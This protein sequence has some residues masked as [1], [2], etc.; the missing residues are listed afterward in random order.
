M[1]PVTS[2]PH[3][4]LFLFQLVVLL[5]LALIF[6][7]VFRRLGLPSVVG[8]ILVGIVL[9][10]SIFGTVAPTLSAALFPSAQT[11][12]LR[13]LAWLG[14]LFLLL[15]AGTE[16]NLLTIK[17]ERRAVLWTSVTNLALPF[18]AGL[19][20]A[21]NLPDRYLVDPAQRW[22][23]SL[24]FATAISISA[25]PLIAKILIDLDLI[26]TTVGQVII[27]SAV[28]QDLIGWIFFGVIMSVMVSGSVAG[29][30]IVGVITMMLAFTLFCLT[31]GRTLMAK[32]LSSSPLLDLPSGGIVGVAVLSA[33]FCAALTEWIGVHAVFGAF[34]AGVM[35]GE[36][37][38]ITDQTRDTLRDFVLY[39]FAPIFFASIGLRANFATEFDPTLVA[40][41]LTLSMAA[42]PL[43]GALGARLGGMRPAE[44]S[45]VGFGTMPQGAMGMIL[46]VVALEHSLIT[47]KMYVALV[48]T[49]IVSAVT[50]GPLIQWALR[51][52]AVTPGVRDGEDRQNVL[53]TG[54]EPSG[55]ASWSGKVR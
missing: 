47:E 7:G 17:R 48:V 9:G 51:R 43:A 18:A 33:F 12:M 2:D 1:S 34:L 8:E 22:L 14:S 6:G 45:A 40:G 53:E 52:G 46:S 31:V 15:V 55:V 25:V 24:F 19:W 35:V 21:W 49:I 27:G 30:S 54:R 28:V 16:V 42:K 32:V 37:G 50:S 36:T 44:A 3:L 29:G 38:K 13:T 20:L 10:P 39:V 26:K 5:S 11:E 23:F 4:A 41:V